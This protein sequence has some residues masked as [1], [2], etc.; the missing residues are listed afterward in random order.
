MKSLR[1]LTGALMTCLCASCFGPAAETAPDFIVKLGGGVV[2][3]ENTPG[4]PITE[5]LLGTTAVTDDQLKELAGLKHLWNLDLV[6]TQVTDK[7]LG[8][9]REHKNLRKL[10]LY[11]TPVTDA[12][13]KEVAGFIHLEVLDLSQT[14]VTDAGLKELLALKELKRLFINDTKVTP[15]GVASFRATMPG[16]EVFADEK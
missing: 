6:S 14:R 2:R 4:K 9:V 1:W 11:G 8:Y 10:H 15:S 12:G 16:C 3:D 13:L 5:V 7:G